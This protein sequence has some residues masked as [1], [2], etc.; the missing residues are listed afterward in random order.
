MPS[1][2]LHLFCFAVAAGGF[3]ALDDEG[4]LRAAAAQ[5]NRYR[6]NP[7]TRTAFRVSTG[8]PRRASGR[9]FLVPGYASV[10]RRRPRSL[11]R[12]PLREQGQPASGCSEEAIVALRVVVVGEVISCDVDPT[13]PAG[14][15]TSCAYEA[16]SSAGK[17]AA[18]RVDY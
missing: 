18:A 10:H 15:V 1:T 9:T 13:E 7:A 4:Q 3:A 12:R 14:G 11:C 16:A 6:T 5:R 2:P 8:L 17:C